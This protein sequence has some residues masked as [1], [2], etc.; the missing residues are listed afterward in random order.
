MT[1]KDTVTILN[2]NRLVESSSAPVSVDTENPEVTIADDQSG[3]AF[4]GANTVT[5]TLTFSEPVQQ[6]PR[7][8]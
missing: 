5:Y 4:D 7:V 1:V 3:I 8:I 6:L 2:D